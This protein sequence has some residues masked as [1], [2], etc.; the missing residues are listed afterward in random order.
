MQVVKVNASKEEAVKTLLFDVIACIILAG[1]VSRESFHKNP[2]VKPDMQIV[3]RAHRRN[4]CERRT[5]GARDV[6]LSPEH[7]YWAHVGPD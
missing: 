4:F 3:Q 5:L 1:Y 6:Y 2:R 7:Q